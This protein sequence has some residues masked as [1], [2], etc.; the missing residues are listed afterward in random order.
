[1]VESQADAIDRQARLIRASGL[2]DGDWYLRRYPDVTALKVDPAEHYLRWGARI[3]RNPGPDF[4]TRHYLK[5]NPDVAAAGLN[6]L[7]HYIKHGRRERRSPVPRTLVAAD[8]SIAIDVVVPVFNAL[9]DV[10]ACLRSLHDR[11][12]GFEVRTLV[13]NDGS[14]EQT[15]AWLREFCADTRG[16]ELIEHDSNRGYTAA[17]NTGLRASSAPYAITLNSDT[18]VTRGWLKGMLRCMASAPG[19]G[20]VGP[21]SNAASWQNVPD[22]YAEDGAFAVNVLPQSVSP[23]DMAARVASASQRTYPRTHFV[24]GFCFM[25]RREVINDIGYMDEQA[26]PV[27]YGEENDFCIR[28]A[29]AGYVLAI[30]DDS[31][32]YHAKSKSFGHQQRKEL[33]R[34]GSEAL[35][36]KHGN[37]KF[38]R[39][40]R[41][42]K[43]TGQMDAVRRRIRSVLDEPG[44][45]SV[46]PDPMAMRVLY[47][48]PV[49]GGGGGAHSVVQEVV[50]MRR[51]GM[52]V[53]VAVKDGRVAS[54]LD[55]Y[56]DVADIDSVFAGF[57]DTNLLQLASGYDVVVGTIFSSMQLVRRICEAMP[58]ILPAYYV[59]DYE[60]LFFPEGSR[61]WRVARDSYGLV[62]NA[63][64]F[65]KTHWIMQKVRAEHGVVVHKV[66]PSI[67][68]AVYRPGARTSDGRIHIAAMIRPQTPRRGAE[69]TMRIFS[70][71]AKQHPGRLVFH[72]FGCAPDDDEFLRLRRDFDFQLHGRLLRPEVAALLS[73]CDLFVDLSDYQAFGRTAL[74]A[75]ACGCA[76]MVPVHGGTDEY[77]IAKV[78]ALVVDSLDETACLRELDELVSNPEN[79]HHMRMRGLATAACYTVHAAAVSEWTLLGKSLAGHR[80]LH[81]VSKPSLLLLSAVT[82]GGTITGSGYVRVALPF[83]AEAILEK[84]SVRT[85]QPGQLPVP[86]SAEA[87]LIQRDAPGV[88]LDALRKWT[89]AWR[90]HGGR[91]I[92]EIDDDLLDVEALR[93]RGYTG[94]VEELSA[95]ID[96]L[97]RNADVLTTSTAP[98]AQKLEAFNANVHTVPN[99]LDRKL[100]R[101]DGSR[102][103]ASGA[104]ARD[105]RVIRIGYI[106]TPSHDADLDLVAEAM[107]RIEADFPGRVEI[108]VIGGFQLR[109]PTFGKR[110]GLPK[111]HDYPNFVDWLHKRVH[112]DIGIIP[113]ADDA[114]N[115]SKSYVKFLEYAALDMAIVC[116]DGPAYA[117]VA[118]HEEN[119]LVVQNRTEAWYEA[120][121]RLVTDAA[122]RSKLAR[123][124]RELVASEHTLDRAGQTYIDLLSGLV[125][126]PD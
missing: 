82:K 110:V 22:L 41:E 13:V 6:P 46:E 81:P 53:H 61:E 34:R 38:D 126:E 80:G 108:E 113:L 48:L 83:Y 64:L 86:G 26:F 76:A 68:H 54:F 125:G 101:L 119:A 51:L 37:E 63:I 95:K 92:Y 114:F 97:A 32:V 58:H 33:S 69:R 16:F 40:V 112:W 75:M 121:G 56:K 106:G 93:R 105:E 85:Q 109:E 19:I 73:R 84:W 7:V 60:P 39:L 55:Q 66:E 25:I 24:N 29:D 12:D 57:N 23:D 96:W 45:E 43:Q 2:F 89:A 65:A 90:S 100:W 30:A 4:D 27:G 3:F 35:K 11:R 120:V 98:L 50:E 1:M 102:D 103:H 107:N 28:A 70:S 18:I 94:D 47:L 36:H 52:A 111:K 42:V 88:P 49:S 118:R 67:D 79:L 71:L 74:E 87:L 99:R 9:E 122:L 117:P 124:A 104:Y 78:N 72:L 77:A 15:S 91:I 116:S 10:K 20:I 62:P 115:R 59:Q 14:D 31:Y 21:L 17:V 123:S 44:G 8:F 5:S